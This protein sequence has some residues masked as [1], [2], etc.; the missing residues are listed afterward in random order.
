MAMTKKILVDEIEKTGI[1]VDFDR[2]Y[3]MRKDKKYLEWLYNH[4]QKCVEYKN[5]A[6]E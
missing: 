2:N 1:V 4:C 3:L 6:D 5:K